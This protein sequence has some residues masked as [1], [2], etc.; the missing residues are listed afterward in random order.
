MEKIKLYINASIE[1]VKM[2]IEQLIDNINKRNPKFEELLNKIIEG[3]KIDN[4]WNLIYAKLN[5]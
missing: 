5:T 3:N 4:Y 2:F 1:D